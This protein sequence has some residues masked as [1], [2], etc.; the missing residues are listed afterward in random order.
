MVKWGI[1]SL[2]ALWDITL[3]LT[4]ADGTS[5]M[6]MPGDIMSLIILKQSEDL[7]LKSQD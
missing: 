7:S 5:T 4:P 6:M 2:L 3:P 1:C